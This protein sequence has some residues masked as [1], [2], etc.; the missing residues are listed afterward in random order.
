MHDALRMQVADR[1]HYLESVELHNLLAQSLA[2]LEDLVK[3][4]SSNERHHKVE[5]GRRLE[6]VLHADK[7]WMLTA[8]ENVLLQL[9]VLDLVV[10]NQD[11]FPDRLDRILILVKLALCQENFSERASAKKR[12]QLE[13]LVLDLGVFTVAN[14]D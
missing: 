1:H 9:R 12:N 13:V 6:Q 5:T 3:L 4:S 8:K 10:L 14:E 7:E 2:C 11:V